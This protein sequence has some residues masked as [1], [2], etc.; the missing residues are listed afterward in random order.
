ML[1]TLCQWK[2]VEII[3]GEIC[4]DH[5]YMLLSIPPK[6]SV[7]GFMGYL[8]GKSSLMIFQKWGEHEIC[9]PGMRILVQGVLRR[10]N[11][12]TKWTTIKHY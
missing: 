2:G 9:V 10:H 1:R 8:R 3:E 6:M 7:S 12:Q 11:E 4:P 5:I